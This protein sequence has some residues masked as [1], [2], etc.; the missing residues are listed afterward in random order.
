M[1][2][3]R[4]MPIILIAKIQIKNEFAIVFRYMWRNRY[5]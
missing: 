3:L 4:L 1:I 2:H 5:S